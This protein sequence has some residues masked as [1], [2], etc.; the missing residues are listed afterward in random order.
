MSKTSAAR[1]IA[2]VSSGA[3]TSPRCSA[4]LRMMSTDQRGMSVLHFMRGMKLGTDRVSGLAS[5]RQ[6]RVAEP[7]RLQRSPLHRI[8]FNRDQAFDV[9]MHLIHRLWFADDAS[10][11]ATSVAANVNHRLH[12]HPAGD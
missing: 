10:D 12:A 5:L 3:S 4:R 11:F 9:L 6:C 1:L 8:G 2:A 7:V